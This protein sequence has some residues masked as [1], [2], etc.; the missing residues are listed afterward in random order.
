MQTNLAEPLL[1]HARK[2]NQTDR[3]CLDNIKDD[4]IGDVGRAPS[5][6]A[7]NEGVSGGESDDSSPVVSKESSQNVSSCLV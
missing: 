4:R 6:A 2:G 3:F 1:K 5:S 7:S